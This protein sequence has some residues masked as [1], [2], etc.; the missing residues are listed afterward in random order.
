LAL[1]SGV[2]FA[3]CCVNH[4]LYEKSEAKTHH[5]PKALCAKSVAEGYRLKRIDVSSDL[6]NEHEKE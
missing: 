4:L 5:T 3:A 1:R 6:S 2:S